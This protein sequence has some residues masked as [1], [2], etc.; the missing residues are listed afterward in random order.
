MYQIFLIVACALISISNAKSPHV[1]SV[2][3]SPFHTVRSLGNITAVTSKEFPILKQLSLRRLILQSSAV[4]EPH[5][6]ANANE[7]TYCL[8]S[9]SYFN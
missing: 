6:H 4:R 1:Y 9:F 2:H 5:W 3:D 7:L 8:V